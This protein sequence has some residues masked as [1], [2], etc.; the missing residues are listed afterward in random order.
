M[1]KSLIV[2]ALGAF[3][4]AGALAQSSVTV[5]GIVDAGLVHESGG[6]AGSVTNLSSGIASGSRIGFKG[7]EDLGGGL[8]ATFVVENGFNADTGTAGQG[9]LLFGR[10]A[11]VGLQGGFGA[12][13]L[14]RQY[15]PYYK[16]LRDV[17]DPFGA[18]T[19]AGRAGNLMTTNTRTDNLVEYLSPR[20]N[21]WSA[22]VAY[23]AGEIA[24]D[25]AKNRT[26]SGAVAYARGALKT[27]LAHHRIDNAAATDRTRNTLLV[28]SYN[29]GLLTAH[30]G[31]AAN[32]GAGNADSRDLVVGVAA[33]LGGIGKMLAS[34]VRRDDRTVAARDASQWGLGYVH[35][36]SKRTD[37]Y[38]SYARIHNSTGATF[39]V[40]NATD[41]GSGDRAFN[42]GVRHTF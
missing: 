30:A 3:T 21:G 33:R 19:L 11:F 37:I 5:Y 38:S 34:Y 31:Y 14:G 1:N 24:G 8:A 13:T 29:F 40:G 41:K 2:L 39:R 27:Q 23:G 28:A 36:L 35:P 6:L 10:Q 9:G 25:S 26:L 12:I 7:K 17:G 42:L 4:S 22:D 16:A 32:K 18:V 15:T 20:V